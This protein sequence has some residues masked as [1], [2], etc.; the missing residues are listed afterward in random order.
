MAITVN[1]QR[2]T[3]AVARKINDAFSTVDCLDSKDDYSEA[4]EVSL[5]IEGPG[6]EDAAARIAA[7]INEQVVRRDTPGFFS[8]KPGSLNHVRDDGP[9]YSDDA[10]G[11]PD[12]E[13]PPEGPDHWESKRLEVE[14]VAELQAAKP[15]REAAEEAAYNEENE[16]R[17]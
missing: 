8:L 14:E 7:L 16:E 9:V 4:H 13:A 10:D 2:I 5:F 17:D 12:P 11:I 15:I 1:M 6:H 3:R